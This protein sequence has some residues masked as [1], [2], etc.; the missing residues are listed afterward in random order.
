MQV[1]NLR[2][3]WDPMYGRTDLSEFEY[4]IVSAPEFQRLRY[5][6]MCNINSMLITGASEINRFE[7]SLGVLRL[8]KEWLDHHT[9]QVNESTRNNIVAAAL[10]HDMVTGPFGHSLQYVLEDNKVEGEF[11]HDDLGYSSTSSYYQDL[12]AGA[13]FVGRPFSAEKILGEGWPAVSE[14]ILGKGTFGGLISGTMDLDNID[15][16]FRLAY[17]VGVADKADANIAIELARDIYPNAADLTISEKGISLIERWQKVRHDLYALLLLDWAEFSAK[18]MLTLA[19]EMALAKKL[20]GAEHWKLTDD[21]YLALLQKESHGESQGIAELVKR[22]KCGDLYRPLVLVESTSV[23]SYKILSTVEE[24]RAIEGE[25][26]RWAK[27]NVAFKST[28]LAHYIL[29]W[30]KTDRAIKVN[31]RE[32][33]DTETIGMNSKRLLIGIF[34]SREFDSEIA[35]DHVRS[36]AMQLLQKRGLE[37]MCELVDPVHEAQPKLRDSPSQFSLL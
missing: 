37:N 34:T 20:I 26:S 1:R 29:D 30:G 10:L 24:K 22:L 17:H 32:S 4:K 35:K 9:N 18:S 36:Q 25:L 13:S 6:R 11:S 14:L 21:E 27:Q 2:R 7:H 19:T 3:L 28:F 16:V 8:A 31:I 15:N 5:I 33:G 23:E 12:H